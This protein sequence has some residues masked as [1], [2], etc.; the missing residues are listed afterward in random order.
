M[1]LFIYYLSYIY[2][3]VPLK[4]KL[5]A[6]YGSHCQSTS[7]DHMWSLSMRPK[8]KY[9]NISRQYLYKLQVCQGVKNIIMTKPVIITNFYEFC[10]F[11]TIFYY[12]YIYSNDNDN[13]LFKEFIIIKK[14][15]KLYINTVSHLQ[16]SNMHIEQIN[17]VL[18][19]YEQEKNG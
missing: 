10:N 5:F 1:C 3:I 6:S 13:I 17:T 8:N 2:K 4:L 12:T 19:W 14:F 16:L 18:Q 15:F 11:N 9:Y 7:F